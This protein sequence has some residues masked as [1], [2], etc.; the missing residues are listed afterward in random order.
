MNKHDTPKGGTPNDNDLEAMFAEADEEGNVS[1]PTNRVTIPITGDNFSDVVDAAEEALIAG[2]N[3]YQ[4]GKDIVIIGD[5]PI[6]LNGKRELAGQRIYPIGD[7]AMR[8]ALNRVARFEKFDGRSKKMVST[9][10]PKDIAQTLRELDGQR[11]LPVLTSVLDHPTIAGN[12]RLL[13]KR[14]YDAE[15]GLFLDF[16]EGA[17]PE[18][19]DKPTKDDARKSLGGLLGLVPEF[20]F[21]TDA[22]R[23]VFLSGALTAASRNA[24]DTAPAF[25]LTAPTPRTGKSKLV[26]VLHAIASGKSASVITVGASE[27]ELEKRLDSALLAGV[28]AIALDNISQA[29]ESA[30]LCALLTQ[31]MVSARR[32]G[33]SDQPDTLT[34]ILITLTGNNLVLIGDLTQRILKCALDARM[35]RPELRTFTSVDPVLLVKAQREKFVAHCLTILRAFIVADKPLTPPTPFGGFEDWSNWIRAALIWLD[36][37]DPCDTMVAAR[38]S[39]PTLAVL[40]SVMGQWEVMMRL[41]C[42]VTV[43]E[44]VA[45]AEQRTGGAEGSD[46]MPLYPEFLS[47]LRTA[48]GGGVGGINSTRL[49]KWL[50]SIQGRVLGSGDKAR[51]LEKAG[52]RNNVALWRLV[53]PTNKATPQSDDDLPF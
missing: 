50:S 17:F 6:I 40:H 7:H 8:K 47:A 2:G 39:D 32:L 4:R 35:D 48:A 33:V 44:L 20:P 18:L 41:N 9:S 3:Y 13:I 36:Q 14:G 30:K 51:M 34:A 43:S 42:A 25:G 53:H 38:K 11:R 52:E 10:P 12:G 31:Q 46:R 15:T 29:V 21:V 5:T 16:K 19:K 49:G 22:D 26:D 24:F 1:S 27:E 23:S 45:K 37:A 28:P